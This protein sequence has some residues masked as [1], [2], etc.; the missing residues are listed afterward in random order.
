MAEVHKEGLFLLATTKRARHQMKLVNSVK[1]KEVLFHAIFTVGKS[2]LRSS[3]ASNITQNL[4]EETF[5][6]I[7]LRSAI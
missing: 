2:I 3:C 5:F 6:V 1:P 4:I 7:L